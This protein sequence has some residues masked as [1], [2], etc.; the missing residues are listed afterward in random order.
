M[1]GSSRI[2]LKG[3]IDPDSRKAIVHQN[4]LFYYEVSVQYEVAGV[5]RYIYK[6]T[7][8]RSKRGE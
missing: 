3:D 4:F 8:I 5:C 1:A 6:R 7:S 2:T